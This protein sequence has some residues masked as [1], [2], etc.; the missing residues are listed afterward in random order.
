MARF[1]KVNAQERKKLNDTPLRKCS[2]ECYLFQ[3][4]GK[5]C[6]YFIEERVFLGDTCMLDMEKMKSYADAFI[7]GSNDV[8]K[9][10]ASKI[11]ASLMMQIDRMIEKVN[12]DGVTVQEPILDGKGNPIYIRDPE[13]NGEGQPTTIVAMRIHEHPL[14]GKIIQLTKSIG[15]NLSEFKL[16]PKSADEKP[17]VSGHIIVEKPEKL[18]ELMARRREEEQKWAAAVEVGNKMTTED[19]VWKAL[20]SDNDTV[21]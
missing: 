20:M 12:V 13:W 18:E 21:I 19:S 6:Q 8:I 1:T 10:D 15:V 5:G 4:D 9:S 14:I 11:T 2:K 17:Q 16:T 3:N 7:T